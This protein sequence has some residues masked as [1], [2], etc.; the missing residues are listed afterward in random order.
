MGLDSLSANPRY[1]LLSEQILNARGED[2]TIAIDGTERLRTTVRLDRARGGL[3]QHPV[4]RADLARPVRGVLERLAGDRGRAGGGRRELAVPAGQGA[5]ARDPDPALRAGDRHPQR[6]AQGAGRPPAGVVRRALDH[7][8]LRPVRGERPLLPGAAAGHR[9]RGPA[10]GARGRRHPAA[11]R[12]A[13]AQRHHLPLEPPGLRRRR[14]SAA[15]AGREP[16]ARRR[17]D[18]RR[19]DR[20][21]GVLLRA[22]PRAGRERAAAVVADVL[23]RRGGELPRRRPAGH[24]R[25]DLLARRRAGARDRAGA[26]PAAADGP[27][28]PGVVGRVARRSRTGCSGSS[29][30][31]ACSAPTA[32]SGSSSGCAPRATGTA[33]TRCGPRCSTT[34][35]GCTPTSPRTPGT[36]PGPLSGSAAASTPAVRRC[37]GRT[38][39]A[40]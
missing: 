28:G 37:A 34:A 29:S 9:R 3:H 18:G 25:P 14:G 11:L 27:R 5:V 12:A 6:G 36:E 8:G 13:A 32:P 1:K 22:G 10:R 15:P 2:I 26:A 19:H 39:R 20:Q 16:A 30:S 38:S 17:P 33:T 35:S 4:P 7:L 23:Q 24:R 31:A 40:G 21:R